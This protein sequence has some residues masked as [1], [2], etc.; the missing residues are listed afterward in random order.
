M[1]AKCKDAKWKPGDNKGTFLKDPELTEGKF[2]EVIEENVRIM[3]ED[4]HCT[5]VG[6]NLDEI[7]RP[8]HIFTFFN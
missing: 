3:N 2:Y 6:D 8:K 7:T 5:V 1:R 4:T